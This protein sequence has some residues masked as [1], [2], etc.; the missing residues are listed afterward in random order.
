MGKWGIGGKQRRALE[1]RL[2]A[3]HTVWSILLH[4]TYTVCTGGRLSPFTFSPSPQH[5]ERDSDTNF[6]LREEMSGRGF[7]RALYD[8][9]PSILR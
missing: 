1:S 7:G 9:F 3:L 4:Y 6:L 5:T 8:V 2:T